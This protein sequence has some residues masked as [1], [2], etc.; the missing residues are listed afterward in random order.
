MPCS[1]RKA[2]LL[3]KEGKAKV[4]QREPF[5]IQLNYGSS[6]YKQDITVGVDT[7]HSEV[8]VS[9]ITPTKELFSFVF[10]LRNDISIK[11]TTK[12]MYR[13]YRRNRLRYRKPRFN[14][15]S[16]S[17]RKGRLA[18]SVSAKVEAHK[19]LINFIVSRL[20]K[21]KLVLETAT[22]DTQKL[23]NDSVTNVQY[24]MGVQYGYSNVRQ[25]VLARDNYTCQCGDK[26]CTDRLEVHHIKFKSQGGSDK[27]N[28]LITLCS[29]HHK[30][31]HDGEWELKVKRH[32][33][34][35]SASTMSVI[36]K[37]LLEYYSMA[38]ETFGYITKENRQRLGIPKSHENDAFVISGGEY[39]DRS[40]TQI[41][42]F[43]QANNRSIGM[44]RKGFAPT[45]RKIRYPIQSGDIIYYNKRTY[46]SKGNS[47]KG[48]SI[49]IEVN[50]K[51]KAVS[52]KN[53]KLIYNRK[54][55]QNI[56]ARH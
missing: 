43:K 2:R 38:I 21:S 4:I 23:T 39:Q 56:T 13:K 28:N 27:P 17:K 33:S 25:Y 45:A 40:E 18:P 41:Y 51:I 8:G 11:M 12:S 53:V 15:R 24:K 10:K 1:Q 48:R 50:N 37:R 52:S 35:N 34:L 44:N 7:G 47:N 55:I 26:S 22:F 30:S 20:P 29:K 42:K 6:G 16:S 54:N 46:I 3:L 19:R 49:L 5:T 36:R 9:V 31:L 32:K 14:N